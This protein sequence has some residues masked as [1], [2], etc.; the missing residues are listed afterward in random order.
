MT[1]PMGDHGRIITNVSMAIPHA[2][3]SS[4]AMDFINNILQTDGLDGPGVHRIRASVYSPAM[5]ILCAT[6][7]KNDWR[8]VVESLRNQ[9]GEDIAT[10]S[11][12]KISNPYPLGTPLDDVYRW[13]GKYG[14]YNWPPIF[15]HLPNEYE[16]L[17]NDTFDISYGRQT[18]YLLGSSSSRLPSGEPAYPLCQ[19]QV[20]S[21]HQCTTLF[22][23][24]SAGAF[25]AADCEESNHSLHPI[26]SMYDAWEGNATLS[27]KWPLLAGQ[28][29]KGSFA[30]SSSRL[31]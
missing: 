31:E 15:S 26:G 12:P 18:V 22:N 29:F 23:A 28:M 16:M 9:P 4:A 5:H 11:T 1:Q 7:S 8:P 10:P 27:R 6:L 25:L 17:L 21:T 14:E 13:G 19:M 20:S 2:A 24:S 3:V 30:R